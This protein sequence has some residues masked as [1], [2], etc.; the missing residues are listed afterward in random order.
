MVTDSR[1]HIN[2]LPLDTTILTSLMRNHALVRLVT[3]LGNTRL[4]VLELLE[5]SLTLQEINY[6]LS[7]CIIE[8]LRIPQVDE[9]KVQNI[10][11]S[12]D[13]YYYSVRR[14]VKLT[15]LG[16]HILDCIRTGQ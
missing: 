11:L 5:Y 1:N 9:S 8:Y 3:I 15:E 2:K 7:N 13:L 10:P 6:A 14:K 4:S 12:P 16:L